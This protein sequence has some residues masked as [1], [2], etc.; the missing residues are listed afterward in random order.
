M[1]R[2]RILPPGATTFSG[3]DSSYLPLTLQF[4]AAF[5]NEF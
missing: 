5:A 4:S 3:K 1:N 2:W